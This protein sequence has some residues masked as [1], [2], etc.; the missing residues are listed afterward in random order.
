MYIYIY[1]YIC[2]YIYMYIFNETTGVVARGTPRTSL[3]G[4]SI[5]SLVGKSISQKG[6]EDAGKMITKAITKFFHKVR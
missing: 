3:V 2:M 5:K 1:I 6:L 4:K